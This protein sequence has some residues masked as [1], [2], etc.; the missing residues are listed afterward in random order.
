VFRD[1]K[2][3]AAFERLRRYLEEREGALAGS[4]E[5]IRVLNLLAVHSAERI[6]RVVEPA[7][8]RD[9]VHVDLIVERVERQLQE[10]NGSDRRH[11]AADPMLPRGLTTVEVPRPNLTLFDRFLSQGGEYHDTKTERALVAEGQLEAA[12]PADHTGR[13]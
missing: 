8:A 11:D 13:V 12:S 1:W 2:L 7:L 3:P 4:R 5:Y 10:P 6:A 9:Q